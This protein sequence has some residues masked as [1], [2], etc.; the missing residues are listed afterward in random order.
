MAVRLGEYVVYGELRNTRNYSTHGVIVLRGEAE[1]EETVVHLELTG[2]CDPDLRGKGFRF[3]PEETDA[4]N[5][6]FSKERYAG[7]QESQIGPTGTMTAQGWVRTMPC[8]VDEFMRRAELNE[9]PPTQWK[10]RLYLEWYSQNGRVVV[11]L[12]GPVVEEC[13][14]DPEGEEDEGDWAPL[15]N[16][17]LPPK[18]QGAQ[19]TQ[20]PHITMVRRDE[21]GVTI[22]D[23]T[24]ENPA[25]AAEGFDPSIPDA[26]QRTLD[27]EAEAVDRA[28]RAGS[29][30]KEDDDIAEFEL[31]DYCI[32]HEEQQAPASLLGD[33]RQFPRPETLN[34]EEVESWL[35]VVLAQLALIGVAL[36]V[37]E[38]FTP[39][40]CYVLLLDTILPEPSVYEKLIG[41]GWV[42]HMMTHE[43]CPACE[44][45]IDE[46]MADAE[47]TEDAES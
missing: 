13:T 18:A 28:I 20:G 31:M 36:G 41:T 10:R 17:A 47:D 22:E 39:R 5:A 2:N 1:G 11:E 16:L 40:D 33:M 19:P 26:L 32:D 30:D 7:F 4:P 24:P 14:R 3:W 45:E 27:A 15:P 35:K 8:P 9:P 25:R 43:Y 23:W 6:V 21:D 29:D 37:C 46:T 44:A 34:D 42:Q 38:H 12:A